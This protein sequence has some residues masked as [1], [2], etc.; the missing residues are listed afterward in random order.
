MGHQLRHV[1]VPVRS[2]AASARTDAN[3]S[4]NP[5]LASNNLE[6]VIPV[7]APGN[8]VG[9]WCCQGPTYGGGND[10]YLQSN[11]QVPAM[12]APQR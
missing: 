3:C 2:A 5:N 1:P 11:M 4:F 10:F 8:A 6:Y 12:H 7:N 9:D